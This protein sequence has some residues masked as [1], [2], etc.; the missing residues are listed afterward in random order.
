MPSYYVW[1]VGCQMNVADSERLGAHL[2]RLG[3]Q[4]VPAADNADIVVINSCV[5]RQHAEDRVINKVHTLSRLKRDNKERVIALMGCMVGPKSDDLRKRFPLVDV[6]MRPQQYEPLLEI[7]RERADL[8]SCQDDEL[9]VPNITGPTAFIPIIKGCDEFCTFCIVPYRRGRQVSRPMDEIVAEARTLAQRGVREVTL[10]GQ[11][12]DAYGMDLPHGYDLAD[13]LGEVNGI[14]ELSRIRFTTS[15]PRYMTSKLIKAVADLDKVCE[16]INLPFQAGDDEVLVRMRRTYDRRRYLEIVQEIKDTVPGIGLST[17][18]IVGFP[19]ETEEQFESTLEI[20]REVRYD[21]VHVA[22][23]STRPGTIGARTMK[24]DISKEIKKERLHRIEDLQAVVAAENNAPMV[25][26]EVEVL[27][28]KKDVQGNWEG[29]TRTLK[30]VHIVGG[31]SDLAGELVRVKVTRAT[32]WSLSGDL[33]SVG[34]GAD[35]TPVVVA[36]RRRP[37][38]LNV[39][40]D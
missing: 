37:V 2:E 22:A 33:L 30:P 39:L 25:G 10:L 28:E 13:L 29:R 21:V 12:V 19:G 6:F 9:V 18:V 5:V 20:L 32:A 36:E 35:A 14:S 40:N 23:Y 8:A 16:H 1:T 4:A 38:F 3:Y 34:V 27:V 24:D 26:Q 31:V 17:D 15:H 11:T 7:A